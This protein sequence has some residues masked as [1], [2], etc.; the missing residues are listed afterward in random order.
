KV[1]F[2]DEVQ[3]DID[4]LCAIATRS[5]RDF[6]DIVSAVRESPGFVV[7]AGRYWYVTPEIVTEVLFAE[8][9]R[10]WVEPNLAAL[11][12][13][14]PAHLQEHL[15]ERAGRFGGEEVRRQVAS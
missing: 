14:L 6:I 4:M 3:A 12:T 5:R 9:W 15:I 13:D 2:R 7:Q 1:G 10:R 11:L 8:G